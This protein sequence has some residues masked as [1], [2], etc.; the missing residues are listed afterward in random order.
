MNDDDQSM[1]M[2]NIQMKVIRNSFQTHSNE[3]DIEN[4]FQFQNCHCQ[5]KQTNKKKQ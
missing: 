5:N 2:A 3:C 1:T 4:T